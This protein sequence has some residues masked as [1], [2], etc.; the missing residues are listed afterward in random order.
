MSASWAALWS[1]LVGPVGSSMSRDNSPASLLWRPRLA[2]DPMA[3]LPKASGWSWHG[4]SAIKPIVTKVPSRSAQ[5][6]GQQGTAQSVT[7]KQLAFSFLH[8]C[9]RE[10][11]IS[12]EPCGPGC[13]LSNATGNWIT[14]CPKLHPPSPSPKSWQFKKC[15]ERGDVGRGSSGHH[16]ERKDIFMCQRSW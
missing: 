9:A 14:R 13:G 10:R 4:A 6:C 16:T 2:Q 15:L 1:R 7:Q 3:W 8:V 12:M 11:K 5:S